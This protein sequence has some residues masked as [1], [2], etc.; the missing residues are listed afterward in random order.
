MKHVKD[1]L[2]N[3]PIAMKKKKKELKSHKKEI[4]IIMK[5][6]ISK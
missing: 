3:K 5:I 6:N 4:I 1:I 2:L